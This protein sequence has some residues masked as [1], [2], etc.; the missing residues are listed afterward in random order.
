MNEIKF[1]VPG[2]AVGKQSV[3]LT[4]YG[5][6]YIPKK[7]R[8]YMNMVSSLCRRATGEMLDGLISVHIVVYRSTRTPSGS[9]RVSK[10]FLEKFGGFFGSKPDCDNVSKAICD[11]CEGIAYKNDAS[12]AALTVFKMYHDGDDCVVVNIGEILSSSDA[13]RL[14][15]YMPSE[16]KT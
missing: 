3:R 10:K 7:T 14:L 13:L 1:V 4:A 12:V 2:P 9:R 5:G 6:A 11:A 15:G 8:D 16:G